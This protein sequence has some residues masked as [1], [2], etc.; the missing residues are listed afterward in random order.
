MLW[1]L[2]NAVWTERVICMDKQQEKKIHYPPSLSVDKKIQKLYQCKAGGTVVQH[3]VCLHPAVLMTPELDT[4]QPIRAAQQYHA[5]PSA[6]V[7]R[8][9]N[10]CL[11]GTVITTEHSCTWKKVSIICI[12]KGAGQYHAFG[13]VRNIWTLSHHCLNKHYFTQEL[14]KKALKG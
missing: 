12:Q 7:H 5:D 9:C 13:M 2:T 1:E 11:Q 6:F 3:K 8:Q 14:H 4:T 10:L